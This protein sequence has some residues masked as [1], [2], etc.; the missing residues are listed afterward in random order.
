[1]TASAKATLDML[2][3]WVVSVDTLVASFEEI[4]ETCRKTASAAQT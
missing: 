2:Q 4:D 1:M 3:P